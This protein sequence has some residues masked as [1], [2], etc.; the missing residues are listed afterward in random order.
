VAAAAS[1]CP[2]PFFA[3]G[4]I[5]LANLGAVVAAGARRVAV[6]RAITAAPDP[7]AASAALLEALARVD[8]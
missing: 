7:Q 2:V 8:G 1:A 5:N 3:I 4:G 6:V